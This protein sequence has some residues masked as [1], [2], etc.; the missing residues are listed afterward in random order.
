MSSSS[1]FAHRRWQKRPDFLPPRLQTH[2]EMKNMRT[3]DWCDVKIELPDKSC[4]AS[5]INVEV[6]VRMGDN[7]DVASA[8]LVKGRL[9]RV[10]GRHGR[11]GRGGETKGAGG[12][13]GIS[14]E[15]CPLLHRNSASS[16][17]RPLSLYCA[18]NR[19]PIN[20][21]ARISADRSQ[22][23]TSARVCL[24][25]RKSKRATGARQKVP[26]RD[27]K[28]RSSCL[29]SFIFPSRSGRPVTRPLRLTRPR[30]K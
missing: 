8:L 18:K 29:P 25:D 3:H 14:N 22:G 23:K 5:W 7:L 4:L 30:R 9:G 28:L 17:R 2:S 24:S 6:L 20:R 21:P 1:T 19:R 13:G 11:D 15:S 26:T 12:W 10:N 16:S 27:S